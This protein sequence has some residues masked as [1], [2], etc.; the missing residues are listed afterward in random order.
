[1]RYDS[2][3]KVT[4]FIQRSPHV[5]R[6]L[7]TLS[8]KPL[9]EDSRLPWV[10]ILPIDIDTVVKFVEYFPHLKSLQLSGFKFSAPSTPSPTIPPLHAFQYSV[11]SI[12]P[13]NTLKDE[14]QSTFSPFSHAHTLFFE[15]INFYHRALVL[16]TWFSD[17][18][19]LTS[20]HMRN[21]QTSRYILEHLATLA[22]SGLPHFRE[23][24]FGTFWPND[25]AQLDRF[26][27]ATDGRL[28]SLTLELQSR[29]AAYDGTHAGINIRCYC[30]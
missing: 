21:S 18:N 16:P 15:N 1:M 7:H 8:L 10:P 4:E 22:Q 2:W 29:P 11:L 13:D 19:N 26:M 24:T 5:R 17:F 14:F 28:R 23:A 3:E 12:T 30:N 25:V 9:L 20:F 6:Q 27:K